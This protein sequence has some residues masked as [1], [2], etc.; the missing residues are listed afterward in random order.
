MN[1]DALLVV[2][3]LASLL[4]TGL[5]TLGLSRW[6]RLAGGVAAGGAVVGAGLELVPAARALL[7]GEPWTVAVPWPW[8]GGAFAIGLDP[9]SA[10]FLVP[11][12]VLGAAAAVYGSEY[13]QPFAKDKPL[14]FPLFG[15]NLLLASLSLVVVARGAVLFLLGWET[16]AVAAG[17]LVAFEHERPEA[18]RAGWV[19]LVVA[20]LG[21]MCLFVLFLLLKHAAGSYGFGA[22]AAHPPEGGVALA[23]GVLAFVGFGSKVGFVPLHIWLPEAHAAAP[24]HV[25]AVM[26]GVLLKVGFYGLLRVFLLLGTRADWWGP[27]LVALGLSSAVVGIALALSQRDLKRALAYSSIENVGLVALGL[28]VGFWAA[29]QGLPRVAALG[30][31]G[32]LLHLWNHVLMK[33]GLFLV[34]GSV[35]HGTGT[36]DLERLGGLSRR[37]PLTAA[38]L[39]V[40]AVALAALPPLNGFVGEWL[41]YLGLLHLGIEGTPAALLGVGVLALVGALAALAFARLA[42][43]T[44]LGHP[45]SPEA[46][47]AHESSRW[48]TGPLLLLAF[49]SAAVAVAPTLVLGALTSVR[50]QLLGAESG[51]LTTADEASL[52]TLGTFNLA[53]WAV[54]LTGALLYRWVLRRRPRE[55]DATWGCGYAA[56]D[57]RMQYGA[58]SFSEL[59]AEQVLPRGA[60]AGGDAAAAAGALPPGQRAV[61]RRHRPGD[62]RHLAAAVRPRR[63]ALRFSGLGAAGPGQRVPGLRAAGAG[64]GAGVDQPP[65]VG[66]AMTPA[67]WVLVAIGLVSVSGVPGL[68]LP[69]ARGGGERLAAGLLWLGAA[70]ALGAVLAVFSSGAPSLLAW[71]WSVPGGLFSLRVD[72]LA[73]FFLVP[74]FVMGALG[75]TYG[76]EYWPE[77]A[78]PDNGRRL[79]FVYGLIVGGLAMVTVAGNALLFLGGWEVMALAAFMAVGTEDH[80]PA[81]RQASHLYLVLARA[82]TLCLFVLFALLHA[83]TGSFEL[84][85]LVALS[86]GQGTAVF[87][88]ALVGFGAEGGPHA[89]AR[90]VAGRPR[91]RAQ[92]RVGADVGRAPQNRRL[93]PGAGALAG[94]LAALVVGPDAADGG[95]C[96][97]RA[98]GGLRAGAARPQAAAW[99]TTPSR[100]WASSSWAWAW[101]CWAAAWAGWTWWCWAWPAACCTCGTTRSSRACSS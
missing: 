97:R 1:A 92:P 42:G 89:A 53:L 31:A 11:V 24:S 62:A 76:L 21:A 88:L 77:A 41:L 28:G 65:R 27:T 14:G 94:A 79:R 71:A 47:H 12:L 73:A 63:C 54:G 64:A 26:S 23:V 29:S 48:M 78:H 60:G 99:R 86:P 80:L 87:V 100:T 44:L 10:F 17:L 75:G 5:L 67:E 39:V 32:G 19:Y 33:G 25:S 55:A 66:A 98:G 7:G 2:L 9:L 58:R 6:P 95:R 36:R 46:A 16:M 82:A 49:L 43:I 84:A 4:G 61:D 68:F 3:G 72:A 38:G 81:A 90:V 45:R 91:R 51:L 57:A 83:V 34:A 18:L 85:P 70:V 15:F 93:R 30:L 40:G 56:P 96:L 101:R 69:T 22:M 8:L 59:A 35:L 37:M 74:I 20:H 13:L 50:V 52:G